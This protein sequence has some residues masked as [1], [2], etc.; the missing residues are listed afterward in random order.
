MDKRILDE[1]IKFGL[2]TNINIDPN[3]YKDVDELIAKGVITI[4]GAKPKIAELIAKLDGVEL[5]EAPVEDVKHV[6]DKISEPVVDEPVK[7][8]EAPV[9]ES[10]EAP[11]EAPVEESVEAPVE[12]SVEA[13]VEDVKK[14]TAK[15]TTKKTE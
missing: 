1:L 12:E 11:V 3:K 14:T 8:S 2:V 9:E 5:V 4:P 15:K 10:V 13:P 6:D 7:T